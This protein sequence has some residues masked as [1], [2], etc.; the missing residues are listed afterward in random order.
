V[1]GFVH[2]T[3]SDYA[4][5][6]PTFGIPPVYGPTPQ[7]NP[8]PLPYPVIQLPTAPLMG[9]YATSGTA[10]DRIAGTSNGTGTLVKGKKGKAS[11]TTPYPK[12][13]TEA[14]KAPKVDIIYLP[15]Q[16]PLGI[17]DGALTVFLEVTNE[18]QPEV[19]AS[20]KPVCSP[21]D[22]ATAKYVKVVY[23]SDVA[24]PQRAD[25]EQAA[26]KASRDADGKPN[27]AGKAFAG[28]AYLGYHTRYTCFCGHRYGSSNSKRRH[29]HR[30]TDWG[31]CK[32]LPL[33]QD[34]SRCFFCDEAMITTKDPKEIQIHAMGC[35]VLM[36]L[37]S[38][39]RREH[40]EDRGLLACEIN[41]FSWPCVPFV[42][43]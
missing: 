22:T 28:T 25:P 2:R 33:M 42:G 8:P 21:H 3:P 4:T 14:K 19:Y 11:A 36:E 30:N 34:R 31:A 43:A 5:G 26:V 17:W 18:H 27:K 29:H 16:P 10:S 24:F 23:T 35:R 37:K 1:L 15:L 12:D 7:I 32:V 9:T 6:P 39:V 38:L 41:A 13:R 40:L 20:L